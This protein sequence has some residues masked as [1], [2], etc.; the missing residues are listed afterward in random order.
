MHNRHTASWLIT[1]CRVIQGLSSMVEI[2]GAQLYLT[3]TIKPPTGYSVVAIM[4]VASAFG[5]LI[6]LLVV[7]VV[8]VYGSNGCLAFLFGT[9]VALIGFMAILTFREYANAKERVKLTYGHWLYT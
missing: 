4:V 5:M 9:C 6:A 7:T 1:V 3:E 2:I 8:T